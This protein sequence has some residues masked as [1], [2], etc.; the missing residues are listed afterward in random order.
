MK[1]KDMILGDFLLQ[2]KID[3]SNPH[4]IIPIS[5]HMYQVLENKF[6][7]ENN[8]CDDKYLIQIRSQAKSNSIKLPD[9][10]GM[11]KNLNPSL[12]PEK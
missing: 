7:L 1:G 8:S 12:R 2:Q 5:F 6:Y 3:D 4:E 11:R 10:H 9:V